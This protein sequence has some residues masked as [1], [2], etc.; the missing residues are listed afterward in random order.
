MTKINEDFNTSSLNAIPTIDFN[1]SLILSPSHQIDPTVTATP[2]TTVLQTENVDPILGAKE[3][4]LFIPKARGF[5]IANLNITSLIKHIDELR[6]IYM[7]NQELDVLGINETR[8]D[9]DVPID[10]IS[11]DGYTWIAKNRNRSGGGVGFYI[12]NSINF[13]VRQDLNNN[14][15]E[16]LTIEILKPKMKPFLITTWYRPPNSAIDKLKEFEKLLQDIDYED[17]EA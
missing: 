6:I 17:K 1:S 2:I 16:S 14:E 5:K 9:S 3:K 7:H 13:E 15:I 11:I 4:L 10:L 12:R 8:L